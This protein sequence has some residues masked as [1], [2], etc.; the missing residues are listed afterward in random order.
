MI[1]GGV[2]LLLIAGIAFAPRPRSE[3]E[4]LPKWV[5][6]KSPKRARTLMYVPVRQ[7]N[8]TLRELEWDLDL[9]YRAM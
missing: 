8:F 6:S 4:V 5:T 7:A 3:F 9:P 2:V 1:S